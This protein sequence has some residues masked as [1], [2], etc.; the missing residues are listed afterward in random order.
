MANICMFQQQVANNPSADWSKIN[1]SLYT[2]NFLANQNGRG[3]TCQNCLETDHLETQQSHA[4]WSKINTS[5]YTVNFLANQNGRGKTCQNCL[6]T[7]HL[8]TECA[9]AP[10][11]ATY[12]F[13]NRHMRPITYLININTALLSLN[14][15]QLYNL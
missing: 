4:D 6:E 5:L 8:S 1:T 11:R 13:I 9:L 2:V 7:D 10:A 14:H 3:K 15:Y 12:L